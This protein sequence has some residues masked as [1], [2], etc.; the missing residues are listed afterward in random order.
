MLFV[1]SSVLELATGLL[2]RYKWYP[3]PF[4]FRQVH[5][6]LAWII[7][8]SLVIHIGVELPLIH[9][10]WRATRPA[11]ALEHEAL[12]SRLGFVCAIVAAAAVLT[13]TTVGQS[14]PALGPIDLFAPSRPGLGPEALPGN[15]TAAEA[16]WLSNLEVR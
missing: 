3:W 9:D 10:H 4:S 2:N 15:R 11:T 6:W 14:I 13:V 16:K 12:T 7:V 1:A 5:F 8:G